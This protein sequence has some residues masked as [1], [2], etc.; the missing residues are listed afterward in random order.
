MEG[1]PADFRGRGR[2]GQSKTVL[3]GG[4][5]GGHGATGGPIVAFL[6]NTVVREGG[7]RRGRFSGAR[8]IACIRQYNS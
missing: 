5:R 3:V 1:S 7:L 8:P 6:T 2:L 4:R